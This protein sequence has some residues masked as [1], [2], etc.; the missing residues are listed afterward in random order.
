M[1]ARDGASSVQGVRLRITR[2]NTDGS[3]DADFPILTT[4]GFISATF[5]TEFEEGDEITEKAADGSVCISWKADDT[6]KRLTFGLS[7]C[8]P[9]PEAAALLAGGTVIREDN[10]PDGEII[11]Y[12]SPPVGALADNPVAVEIWSIANIGGKPAAG[13]PYWHWAFPFVKI[14]YEGDREFTNGALANEFTGQAFGNSALVASGLNPDNVNDDFVTYKEALTNPFSYVRTDT[15]PSTGWNAPWPEAE[16]ATF[17]TGSGSPTADA[18][19]GSVFVSTTSPYSIWVRKAGAWV[20]STEDANAS[21]TAIYKEPGTTANLTI[22]TPSPT[23]PVAPVAGNAT[24]ME[25]SD[26]YR[27]AQ[28][29]GTSWSWAGDAF[30]KA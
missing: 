18:P 14:R 12:T 11:G 9:D 7:L 26:E 2:L 10:Q 20:D 30:L 21:P 22:A 23:T 19:D 5:G 15:L 29:N 24:V 17:G 4:T 27:V 25:D 3:I 28:H 1:A 13:T 16:A 8:S 6:L